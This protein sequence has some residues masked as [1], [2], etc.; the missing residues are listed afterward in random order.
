METDTPIRAHLSSIDYTIWVT[1]EYAPHLPTP[2]DPM[3]LCNQLMTALGRL[4]GQR[5]SS[6]E[7]TV[8]PDVA[9]GNGSVRLAASQWRGGAKSQSVVETYLKCP[10]LVSASDGV[11][12]V[13]PQAAELIHL[14]GRVLKQPKHVVHIRADLNS[15]EKSFYSHGRG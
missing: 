5:P 1:E 7:V 6:F 11:Q 14:S 13:P 3:Q 12:R 4:R 9:G 10:A 8:R 15:L 2:F